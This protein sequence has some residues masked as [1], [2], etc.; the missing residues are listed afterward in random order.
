MPTGT[1]LVSNNTLRHND[2]TKTIIQIQRNGLFQSYNYPMLTLMT[3]ASRSCI[4]PG[5]IVHTHA[6]DINWNNYIVDCTLY[7]ITFIEN[8]QNKGLDFLYNAHSL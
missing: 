4:K 8:G 7:K 3:C 1:V 5:Y 6:S 2:G